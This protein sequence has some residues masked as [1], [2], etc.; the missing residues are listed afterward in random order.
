MDSFGLDWIIIIIIIIIITIFF[1]SFFG[2]A[3]PLVLLRGTGPVGY[4][5]NPHGRIH[6]CFH[7]SGYGCFRAVRTGW[8]SPLPVDPPEGPRGPPA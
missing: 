7:P 1:L 6:P 4:R 5:R 2:S 8:P 3:G